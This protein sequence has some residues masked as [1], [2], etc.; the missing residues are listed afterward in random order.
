MIISFKHLVA[1]MRQLWLKADMLSLPPP[2][3]ATDV[4]SQRLHFNS[5]NAKSDVELNQRGGMARANHTKWL[6]W[7][8]S[9]AY[10]IMLVLTG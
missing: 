10:Q 6:W 9:N 5:I 4:H 2:K 7:I 1:V 8:R 3:G